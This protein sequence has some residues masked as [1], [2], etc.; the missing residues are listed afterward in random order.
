MNKVRAGPIDN[1]NNRVQSPPQAQT[2]TRQIVPNRSPPINPQQ[3][4]NGLSI[5]LPSTPINTL[6]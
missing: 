2:I 6:K 1:N 5:G 4:L 3:I